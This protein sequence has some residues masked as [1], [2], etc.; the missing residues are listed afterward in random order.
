MTIPFTRTKE[1]PAM[2][3]RHRV[4]NRL[5]QISLRT[6]LIVLATTII[7]VIILAITSFN[8]VSNKNTIMEQAVK[9]ASAILDFEVDNFD[10]YMDDINWYSLALRNDTAF[11]QSISSTQELTY[12]DSNYIQSLLKSNYYSRND[13]ISYKLYLLKKNILISI[14]SKQIRITS[15]P[16]SDFES[17][18]D[19]DNFTQGKYYRAIHP[20]EDSGNFMEYYRTIIDIS[21]KE[22]LAIV[23]LTVDNTL[24][25]SLSKNHLSENEIFCITDQNHRLYY[26][27]DPQLFGQQELTACAAKMQD[28]E[29]HSFY[30]S[31]QDHDYLTVYKTSDENHFNLLV[32]KP[33]SSLQ[34]KVTATRNISLLL[35]LAAL[36][37]SVVL[38]T[39]FLRLIIHPISA[40][41]L[42]MKKAGDGNFT[43]IEPIGGNLEICNLEEEYN[44]ML[45]HIDELIKTNYISKLNEETAKLI[46]LEAQTNPHFLYN[47]L[48]AISSEAIQNHQPKI[49][50]MITSLASLLRYG[51]KDKDM[52]SVNEEI[53]QVQNYLMLQKARFDE[54]LS[55]Q[56][57]VEEDVNDIVIPKLSIT[58]LVENSIMHGMTGTVN[59]IHIHVSAYLEDE[60]LWI[61]VTDNGHGIE[62]ERYAEI[63][64]SFKDI[65][66]RSEHN[67]GIGLSN[68][69]NRMKL[70]Y[71][72]KADI[73][74]ESEIYVGT[75]I[76]L[77]I[78][79]TEDISY[80]SSTYH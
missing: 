6:Q 23:H 56:I 51:I 46:A 11:L 10:S 65:P 54:S 43:S 42:R 47:T 76:T 48:Q 63:V 58:T 62:R 17:I 4:K 32:L 67:T 77:K 25:S 1:E 45:R 64:E 70:V 71:Q 59:S 18:A 26:S 3:F 16:F 33:V 29:D 5:S 7:F 75:T 2:T 28:A 40:L 31:L 79:I 49:N 39:I 14:S 19:Y 74:I 61:K 78:P 80:V 73:C 36:I 13:V 68:L 55:Y 57:D 27:S 52:M 69:Y 15:V 50:D 72:E 35:G 8:Y 60:F 24:P 30:I 37:L 21:T 66:L 22:P 9:S 38:F 20:G 44:T 53:T 41:I 34:E 12:E